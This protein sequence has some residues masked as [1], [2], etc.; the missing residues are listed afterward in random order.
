MLTYEGAAKDLVAALKFHNH[1][2]AVQLLG[3]AMARLVDT[4][5]EGG[6]DAVTWAPTS[7]ARR[8]HRG[9][10]QAELLARSVARALGRPCRGTLDRVA[11]GAQTGHGREER[12]HGPRFRSRPGPPARMLLVDDVRT[13]GAT[14]CA[15]ADTLIG[16]GT[17]DVA[18]L[19][20]AVTL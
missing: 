19:T 8:R 4:D 3:S 11:G 18:G 17:T 2:D 12:L 1:R 9:Y 14:L 5:I 6:I 13:T 16:A 15:A 7:P 10:D 20:L